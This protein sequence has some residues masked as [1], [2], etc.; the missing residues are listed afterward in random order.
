MI[1]AGIKSS[2]QKPS[3]VQMR[4]SGFISHNESLW[5]ADCQE[6]KDQ[7]KKEHSGPY[8]TSG[9][10]AF[11]SPGK[12]RDKQLTFIV[13]V[14]VRYLLSNLIYSSGEIEIK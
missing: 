3:G 4:E 9:L 8:S 5:P 12:K 1:G 13:R 10:L 14:I 2:V 11:T 7:K 6:E